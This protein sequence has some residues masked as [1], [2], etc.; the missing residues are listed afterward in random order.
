MGTIIIKSD[1]TDDL[2]FINELARR[3]GLNSNIEIE[4]TED[5]SIG[6]IK[7]IDSSTDDDKSLAKM[8]SRTGLT[9]IGKILKDDPGGIF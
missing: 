4:I 6:R 5:K 7:K 3:L 8:I 9:N 1:N 2:Y